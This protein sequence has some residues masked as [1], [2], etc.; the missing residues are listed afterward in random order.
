VT[1]DGYR[2]LIIRTLGRA[3]PLLNEVISSETFVEFIMEYAYPQLGD[4]QPGV[5]E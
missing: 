3:L 1:S 2:S 4:T 5:G